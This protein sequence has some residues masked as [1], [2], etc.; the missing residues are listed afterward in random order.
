MFLSLDYSTCWI[1]IVKIRSEI[2]SAFQFIC[3]SSISVLIYLTFSPQFNF[4]YV[5]LIENHPDYINVCIV[6]GISLK[7]ITETCMWTKLNYLT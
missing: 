7:L 4:Y 3:M 6:I 2:P 5:L 1:K